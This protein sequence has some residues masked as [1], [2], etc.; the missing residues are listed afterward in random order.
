[1]N[2]TKRLRSQKA[3]GKAPAYS[4]C[5]SAREP[6]SIGCELFW[7]FVDVF[8]LKMITFVS[9]FVSSTILLCSQLL[10]VQSSISE[11]DIDLNDQYTNYEALT[12]WLDR[13]P[14]AFPHLVAVQT[15]GQ[16]VRYRELW[17]IRIT[18]R[19]EE[20]EP[21]EPKVKYVS[22]IHGNE[23]VGREMLLRFALHLLKSYGKDEAITR[24]I[25]STDIYIMPS[26]NPDGFEVAVEGSCTGVRGRANENGVDLFADFPLLFNSSYTEDYSAGTDDDST[27]EPEVTPPKTPHQPETNALIRWMKENRFVL[28]ANFHGSDLFVAYPL[29]DSASHVRGEPSGTPDDAVFEWLAQTYV[30]NHEDMAAGVRCPGS[31]VTTING[32]INGNSWFPV[33]GLSHSHPLTSIAQSL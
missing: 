1:M 29:D 17:V 21:G 23:P 32:T 11:S 9:F 22:N 15:I 14:A 28:S 25:N 12:V 10:F 3:K 18:D 4:F 20:E 2:L 13:L 27:F 26:M 24:L 31:K 30:H 16:S 5:L 33:E 8:I 19:V 7:C 6:A